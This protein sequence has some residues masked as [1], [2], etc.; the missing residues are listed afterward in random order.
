MLTPGR[1]RVSAMLFCFACASELFHDCMMTNISSIPKNDRM[2]TNIQSFVMYF[3]ESFPIM[4]L[5]KVTLN[6]Q[7]EE[8]SF[9][10][11]AKLRQSFSKCVYCIRLRFQSNC[12]GWL[13]PAKI[14]WNAT[15]CSKRTLKTTVTTQ[16]KVHKYAFSQLITAY[17][18]VT[19]FL[20]RGT[21]EEKRWETTE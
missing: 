12:H 2:I 17:V 8:L 16:L 1:S 20:F 7:I 15:A 14:L 11:K 6:L 10:V 19:I 18:Q 9:V 4:S 5:S 21:W 3:R 13:K